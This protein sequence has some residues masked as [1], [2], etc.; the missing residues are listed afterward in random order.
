MVIDYDMIIKKI[1]IL[2]LLEEQV[3]ENGEMVKQTN[4]VCVIAYIII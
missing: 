2:D 1:I 4:Y 3:K